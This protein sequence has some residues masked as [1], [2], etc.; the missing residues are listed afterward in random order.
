M[1][2]DFAAVMARSLWLWHKL[3]QPPR[4]QKKGPAAGWGQSLS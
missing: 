1:S 3:P 4:P 2:R